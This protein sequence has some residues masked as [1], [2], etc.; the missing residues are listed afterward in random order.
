M[1]NIEYYKLIHLIENEF[2][3]KDIGMKLIF[4]LKIF[5]KINNDNLL[6]EYQTLL[7]KLF[8]KNLLLNF[9]EIIENI[10][11]EEKQEFID[12]L[13]N[14]NI[15]LFKNLFNNI[16][17]S[18]LI[19]ILEK[20]IKHDISLLNLIEFKNFKG[21]LNNLIIIYVY[22]FEKQEFNDITMKIKNIII[23]QINNNEKINYHFYDF[24]F[25][26]CL[27]NNIDFKKNI[28]IFNKD[29]QYYNLNINFNINELNSNS[30]IINVKYISYLLENKLNIYYE[31]FLN[32]I[33]L[34]KSYSSSMKTKEMNEKYILSFIKDKIQDINL[35]NYEYNDISTLMFN[36]FT[37]KKEL[38]NNLNVENDLL[39][40]LNKKRKLLKNNNYTNIFNVLNEFKETKL[41]FNIDKDNK[42]NYIDIFEN[43]SLSHKEK[44]KFIDKSLKSFTYL[45]KTKK[46]LMFYVLKN[47]E[48]LNEIK[49]FKNILKTLVYIIQEQL[50]DYIIKRTNYY[51][52]IEKID[53]IILLMDKFFENDFNGHKKED[54]INMIL[55]Y[56][57]SSSFEI[58]YHNNIFKE[59]P[60]LLILSI[61]IP[62]N[63]YN[64]LYKIFD[65]EKLLNILPFSN[66]SYFYQ[67]YSNYLNI[68]SEEIKQVLLLYI[69]NEN[70]I[71][72][73]IENVKFF[74]E[75]FDDKI[76]T[77]I[78]KNKKEV[79]NLNN[80]LIQ[81][82][83]Y[84]NNLIDLK[85]LKNI[86]IYDFIK[87]QEYTYLI[88]NKTKKLIEILNYDFLNINDFLFNN[89]NKEFQ[90]NKELVLFIYL[91][92]LSNFYK[93]K[94]DVQDLRKTIIK[95]IQ[96]NINEILLNQN[97]ISFL[98]QEF[99]EFDDG[100]KSISFFEILIK[101]TKSTELI[102][103]LFEL[104][105]ELN[106]DISD[107]YKEKFYYM[108]SKEK[109]LDF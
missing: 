96:K 56:L 4:I 53:L 52:D 40:L 86:F 100:E 84:E 38:I 90:N 71:E 105:N 82:I 64:I 67:N 35:N 69:I 12:L 44:L 14:L 104:A 19:F 27:K 102:N 62:K 3:N 60:L 42:E 66:T 68:S 48:S 65:F 55:N 18:N 36:N 108:L 89:E 94:K 54:N 6:K 22:L 98:T 28:T 17:S 97:I 45:T 79:L 95:Y 75:V 99:D 80:L 92:I 88:E 91:T 5:A 109:S 30:E 70:K 49:E 39:N 20:I 11:N 32:Y 25:L 85:K 87:Y 76:N 101:E 50:N 63:K 83:L 47:I 29:S 81:I 107:I 37:F 73:F 34:R 31:D 7:D 61:F 106:I 24:F 2:E 51:T 23:E 8:S 1:L 74:E 93:N 41:S 16:S 57:N 21:D 59:M 78:L 46:Y 58:E 10:T 33:L 103:I 77:F 26:F 72:Y 9:N 13:N 15:V 43:N